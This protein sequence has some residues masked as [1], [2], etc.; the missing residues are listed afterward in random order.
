MGF[1]RTELY[2]L[3]TFAVLAHGAVE[4]WSEARN[5]NWRRCFCCWFGPRKH[6]TDDEIKFVWNPL[7]W[8]LLGFW[9]VAALRL[10]FSISTD[11]A[12]PDANRIAEILCACVFIFLACSRS[13]LVPNGATLAGSCW[14]SGLRFHCLPFCNTPYVQ[15][16]IVL[17]AG[18]AVWRHPVW[19]LCEPE[20]FCGPD[21]V[22]HSAR[23]EPSRSWAR[24]EVDQ[25]PLITLFT[26][27]PIGALFLSASRGGIISLIV[28]VA[29]LAILIVARRR[30]KNVPAL[31]SALIVAGCRFGF[32]AGDWRRIGPIRH[33]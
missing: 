9:V 7:L 17:G 16:K 31:A 13:E 6:F 30:E 26:L 24:S 2:V 20:S 25:L 11:G 33:L 32:V 22:A 21:G 23:P 1:L 28:E 4:P 3:V 12:V 19:T 27:L 14:A 5:R 15:R 18:T 8:P 29:F 10:T